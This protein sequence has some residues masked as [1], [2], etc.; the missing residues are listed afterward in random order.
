MGA[1]HVFHFPRGWNVRPEPIPVFIGFL[2]GPDR[3]RTR[4]DTT[5][6]RSLSG[7]RTRSGHAPCPGN[8]PYRRGRRA[9]TSIRAILAKVVALGAQVRPAAAPGST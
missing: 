1:G 4:P 6:V 9:T 7:G 2:R 3:L 8:I 5:R